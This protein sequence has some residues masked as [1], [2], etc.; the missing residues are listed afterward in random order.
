MGNWYKIKKNDARLLI[1][2]HMSG[3]FI[4]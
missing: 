3:I 2:V 4:Q 1:Q